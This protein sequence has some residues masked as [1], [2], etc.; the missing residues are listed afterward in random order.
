[1]SKCENCGGPLVTENFAE[2]TI[3][4][5]PCGY[6]RAAHFGGGEVQTKPCTL[7]KRQPFDEHEDDSHRL[8]GFRG[9]MS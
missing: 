6:S 3:I 7:P 1:M 9:Y 2:A 5:G 8:S 4:R